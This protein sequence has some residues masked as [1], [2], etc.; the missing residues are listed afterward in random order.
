MMKNKKIYF[1]AIIV[2]IANIT[3]ATEISQLAN[4]SYWLKLGH[5]GPA[6]QTRWKSTIDNPD[7]FLATQGKTNP[8]A[9]L[10]A[11]IA[12]FKHS[13]GSSIAC[14]YPARYQWLKSKLNANW[15][16]L[17]CPKLSQWRQTIDP[18]SIT[19]VFPTAFMNSPSSM[20]GHTLLRIDANGQNRDRELVAFAV[21]F[22][23]A[24]DEN[25]NAALFA[26]KGLVGQYPGAFSL[27]PY[28]RKVREY[29]DLESRDIW[30]YQL[31]F[32]PE[33]VQRILLHLWEL[34]DARFDYYFLDENCSY[35]LLALLQLGSE[36]LD[37]VSSFKFS[38][39]PSET[40]AVLKQHGL[41]NPPQYRP[42]IGTKLLHYAQSLN[43]AQFNASADIVQHNRSVPDSFTSSEQAAILEMSYEWLNYNFY[44]QGLSRS[45]IA[46]R[47]TNLLY[48]R[49]LL[50][51]A[52]PYSE[53]T[54]PLY[55]PDA[56]HGSA[57]IGVGIS[58]ID[59]QS[60]ELDL[61]WRLAYHDLFDRA[62][63]F[64][65]GAQ[66]SFLDA[67]LSIDH[68]GDS[69]LEQLYLLDAMSL[70]PHNR[71]FNSWS[72]NVRAG[73]DR[74]PAVNKQSGRW[75]AQAG[76]GK[77]WG[78]PR[79]LHGYLL[80]S[81]EVN[82]GSI[83][84]STEPGLGVETG[85]IWQLNPQHKLGFTA[86]HGMLFNSINDNHTSTKLI[87]HW[88]PQIDWALRSQINYQQWSSSQ[89]QAQLT[90]LYYF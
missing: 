13:D 8:Q 68:T 44:D 83:T 61:S 5:Y 41:L 53:P 26:F 43:P 24:P 39:I 45:E 50:K 57:R 58:Q 33:Q 20:F 85:I 79:Q 89:L 4:Q 62:G 86:Y 38:A 29:S 75:F 87:W 74:Q 17:N 19:L 54:Q 37:L 30:E 56:G 40:V 46:P 47:L 9:E 27:M 82:R 32:T 31:N 28:Y 35:Q 55:S 15:P 21:N 52:S 78:D 67:R 12:A 1:L 84:Q 72:W 42:A 63:G 59:A 80:G 16:Q 49:S 10:M 14:R 81:A 88:A 77:S 23:A 76:Y 71:I 64:I 73:F 6:I 90:A 34:V 69:K 22:A 25:D 36:E 7:F 2:F 51:V 65:A 70:A 3:N 18:K 66:I 11:T 48:Q 60:T